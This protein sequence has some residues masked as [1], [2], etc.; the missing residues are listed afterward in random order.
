MT[1]SIVFA[2]FFSA[3]ALAGL[4]AIDICCHRRGDEVS[5]FVIEKPCIEVGT[6]TV[7]SSI[8]VEYRI[9]NRGKRP[10]HIVGCDGG[11]CGKSCCFGPKTNA[12]VN[13]RQIAVNPGDTY[14]FPCE[15]ETRLPGPIV[16]KMTLFVQDERLHS[17]DLSISGTA[18]PAG[19][20]ADVFA[21]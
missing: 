13:S 8:E 3:L 5:S 12:E 1:R 18:A 21:Q 16:W 9:T 11:G 7:G 4:A 19:G 15:L 14:I 17:V 6:V 2:L 10:I 20:K